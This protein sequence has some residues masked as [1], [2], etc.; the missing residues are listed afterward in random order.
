VYGTA[1]AK[2]L[3]DLCADGQ[4]AARVGVRSLLSQKCPGDPG[5]AG[6]S[7]LG[8]SGR[9]SRRLRPS[10]DRGQIHFG[11]RTGFLAPGPLAIP[12]RIISTD[13]LGEA[14]HPIVLEI[15][16]HNGVQRL[17]ALGL[18]WC[19]EGDSRS[20]SNLPRPCTWGIAFGPSAQYPL[21]APNSHPCS[22]ADPVRAN[23]PRRQP[24]S[25]P[26]VEAC[27]QRGAEMQLELDRLAGRHFKYERG[28]CM[29]SQGSYPF[30]GYLN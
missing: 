2:G 18:P 30:E 4:L 17:H 24:V 16:V 19:W 6:H 28:H 1:H 23:R 7:L 8:V 20:V 9:R 3:A 13:F 26:D 25:A 11:G 5:S 10:L 12:C 21:P 15:C 29:Q 27:Y 22:A 14:R